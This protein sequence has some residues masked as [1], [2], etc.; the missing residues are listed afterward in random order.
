MTLL[1]ELRNTIYNTEKSWYDML[2]EFKQSAHHERTIDLDDMRDLVDKFRTVGSSLSL[3]HIS[4][5]T[6]PY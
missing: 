1:Y 5:P 3:I 4:E 6:R 2:K